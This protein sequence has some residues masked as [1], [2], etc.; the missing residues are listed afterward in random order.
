MFP[1]DDADGLIWLDG[2]LVPWPEARLNVLT[3]SLH[4]GGAVFEGIRAYDGAIFLGEA[5]FQRFARSAELMGY[6]LPRSAIELAKAAEAVL[7]ANELKEAY[8]R[9]IAWRGS[10]SVSVA[11]RDATIHV[12]VAAWERPTPAV[13][14]EGET[15]LRLQLAAWRRPRAD[16]APVASKCSGLQMI[17]TLARHAALDAGFDDALL[18]D[19][20]DHVAGP[21]ATNIVLVAGQT[22]VSPIADCFLDSITKRHVFGLAQRRGLAIAERKVSLADLRAADEVFVVGTAIEIQPVVALE[23]GACRARWPVGPV[24][25][26]LMDDFQASIRSRTPARDRLNVVEA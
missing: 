22:L 19:M 4:M 18:L 15:G 1:F 17:G 23:S 11:A 25:R 10:E 24:T 5:H 13:R 2:A 20:D 14:G 3:H 6:T 8:I 26:R 16:T 21:T 7:W 12:A 9:P